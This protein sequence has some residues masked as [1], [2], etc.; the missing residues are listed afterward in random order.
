MSSELPP[1]QA[2]FLS[3]QLVDRATEA[4]EREDYKEAVTFC[5]RA[6]EMDPLHMAAYVW[7]ASA[8]A[9]LGDNVRVITDCTAALNTRDPLC[10]PGSLAIELAR[11]ARIIRAYAYLL[12]YDYNAAVQDCSSAIT[13]DDQYPEPFVTRGTALAKL[14]L[15]DKARVDFEIAKSLGSDSVD[16]HSG[17]GFLHF[18]NAEYAESYRECTI[19]IESGSATVDPYLTLSNIFLKY[20]KLEEALHECNRA[21]KVNPRSADAYCNRAAVYSKLGYFDQSLK[22]YTEAIDL[23]PIRPLFYLKQRATLFMIYRKMDGAI[24]DANSMVELDPGYPEGYVT[25]AQIYLE[26]RQFAAA[27]D[28]LE[29]ATRLNPDAAPLYLLRALS[30]NQM[31]DFETALVDSITALSLGA[32]FTMSLLARA[33]AHL[34][35]SHYDKAL[36]D[37]NNSLKD[38]PRADGY[39]LRGIIYLKMNKLDEAI[40]DFELS[41]AVSRNEAIS[42]NARLMRALA[43][44]RQGRYDEAVLDITEVLDSNPN[45]LT[46]LSYRAQICMV[47]KNLNVAL[48]DYDK[49][50]DLLPESADWRQRRGALLVAMGEHKRACDDLSRALEINPNCLDAYFCRGNAYSALTEYQFALHD[51][52]VL[53]TLRPSEQVHLAK[54]AVYMK[55]EDFEKV[56]EEYDNALEHNPLSALVY[57]H[58]SCLYLQLKRYEN[59]LLSIEKALSFQPENALYIAIRGQ[60][61]L[62]LEQYNPAVDQ[63]SKAIELS[64]KLVCAFVWRATAY[65]KLGRLDEYEED[66]KVAA[67]LGVKIPKIRQKKNTEPV[68]PP[69]ADNNESSDNQQ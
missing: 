68:A 8:S 29:T 52:E 60:L 46:G 16:L 6:L 51:F 15:R 41:L 21:I 48:K 50:V 66:R 32:N 53:G 57:Y 69:P 37:A 61:C 62:L 7:R 54:A 33:A 22:D 36:S 59:S 35:L 23:S 30:R 12:K 45:N 4:F 27:I 9:M 64:P 17:L 38:E 18:Q 11:R 47:Q 40:Q 34:G 44:A 25:R 10:Q 14:G 28:D 24:A 58:K 55:M 3:Q 2:R 56:L 49:I 1:A 31:N 63:L 13:L 5:S 39:H 43:L 67:S 19:A 42:E 26:Q 65:E 20:G